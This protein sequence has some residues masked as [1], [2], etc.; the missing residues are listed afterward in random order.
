[1]D[2]A[3]AD[4]L[5]ANAKIISCI[6]QLIETTYVKS[7]TATGT[8][9]V[10]VHQLSAQLMYTRLPKVYIHSKIITNFTSMSN[11]HFNGKQIFVCLNLLNTAAYFWEVLTTLL[12]IDMGKSTRF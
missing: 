2:A 4:S 7:W 5:D 9:H 11:K 1:M 8:C 3:S 6:Q 10:D 12:G